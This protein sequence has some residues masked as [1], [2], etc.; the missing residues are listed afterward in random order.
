MRTALWIVALVLV[1]LSTPAARADTTYV[2]NQTFNIDSQSL[3]DCGP[4]GNPAC[5]AAT[6]TTTGS[7][8]TNGSTGV[9]SGTDVMGFDV[10]DVYGQF[11]DDIASGEYG[12]SAGIYGLYATSTGLF[13][14]TGPG[15]GELSFTEDNGH[16]IDESTNPICA[17]S[18]CT[19][20][21]SDP[22]LYFLLHTAP[23]PG[24]AIGSTAFSG[25]M[26]EIA[27]ATP[28]PSTFLLC[29][30]GLGLIVFLRKRF[31]THGAALPR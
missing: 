12:A 9:L 10:G 20:S 3:A 8:T 30:V 7:I 26:I 1:G 25:D 13:L 21:G 31:A 11:G 18:P 15:G 2:F 4:P 22:A 6:G 5:T 24:P 16:E 28:E 27:T 14:M 17:S 29:F 19:S 23:S